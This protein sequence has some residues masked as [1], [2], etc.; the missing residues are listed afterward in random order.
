MINTSD[1]DRSVHIV[2][3]IDNG[4]IQKE[5][6]FIDSIDN[7]PAYINYYRDGKIYKQVNYSADTI[8]SIIRFDENEETH[9]ECVINYVVNTDDSKKYSLKAKLICEHGKFKKFISL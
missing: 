3:E 1:P 5:S 9:G 6:G 2:F 4:I 7:T 8:Q